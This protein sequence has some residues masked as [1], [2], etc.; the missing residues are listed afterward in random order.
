MQFVLVS[1]SCILILQLLPAVLLSAAFFV[2]R[3]IYY[4]IDGMAQ[5]GALVRAATKGNYDLTVIGGGIIGLATARQ[6]LLKHPK[7]KVCVVEKEK[8]LA[9]HQSKRNSGVVHCGIYYKKGSLK[10]KFCIRGARMVKEYCHSKGLPYNQCG[11]LIV[12]TRQDELETLNKLFA[13][14][15]ANRIQGIEMIT[16][17]RVEQIQPGCTRAIEAIWSPNTAIVDWR[18][19]ALSYA[20]DFEQMGGTVVKEFTVWSLETDG[21][22]TLLLEDVRDKD[23]I[24]KTKSIV[25]CAGVYSDYL[26]RRTG[27]DEHPKVIPFKGNYFMLSD[28]LASTI[29]TNI[30]PVPN[31]KLPFL[32]VHI[33]PRVDGSVLIGP[34]SLLALGYERYTSDEFP[35]LLHLY[36]ILLRSGLRKL[37]MK[38]GNIKAGLLE[39]WRFMS[40]KKVAQ[41]VREFLPEIK[42]EDLIDT[43]FNGIRAQVVEK[44][45]IMVDDFL[46][47]TGLLPEYHR[48]LHVRNCP[49][50]AATSS[51]AIADRV[52]SILEERFI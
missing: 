15:Q 22:K 7:L 34:T 1:H 50:P 5:T 29:K 39:L 47:E 25:N 3:D 8:E 40:P 21:D 16:K 9:T 52:V 32:G 23:S 49:S 12:A 33:T 31:P 4:I 30:Y 38:D 41:D 24:I 13:N 44:N 17:E 28:R 37:I 10:S 19:V 11:K 6:V 27:N 26:A 43:N 45:G 36:H 18:K 20:N 48:V 42:N 35:N 51:L 46:F 2:P 14:A